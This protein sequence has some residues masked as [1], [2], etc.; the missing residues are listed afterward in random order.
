MTRGKLQKMAFF[1]DFR[2]NRCFIKQKPRIGGAL[3]GNKPYIH[4]ELLSF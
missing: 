2:F 1:T 3:W 4:I